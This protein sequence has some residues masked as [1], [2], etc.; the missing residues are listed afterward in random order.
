MIKE[1]T[2]SIYLSLDMGNILGFSD[3]Y[4]VNDYICETIGR[5]WFEEQRVTDDP[6]SGGTM[7]YCPDRSTYHRT[8]KRVNTA[9]KKRVKTLEEL[10]K[11]RI[12]KPFMN[13]RNEWDWDRVRRVID[14]L[15][16]DR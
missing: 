7:F 9:L 4:E 5:D 14:E 1:T 12:V 11:K 2:V 10:E 3:G 15:T 8:R 16:E 6:E 13:V